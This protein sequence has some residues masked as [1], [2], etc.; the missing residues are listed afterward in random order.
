[1]YLDFLNRFS[2][3]HI[4]RPFITKFTLSCIMGAVMRGGRNERG[5]TFCLPKKKRKKMPAQLTRKEMRK[6]NNFDK[7][8]N[9]NPCKEVFQQ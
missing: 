4:N 6:K 2:M 1:M 7:G 3:N 5:R 9:H 8:G